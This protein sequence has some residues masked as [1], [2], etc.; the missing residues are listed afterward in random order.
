MPRS[1]L[2]DESVRIL[3][4]LADK[5][6]RDGEPDDFMGVLV[7][8]GITG[9]VA[10]LPRSV[11]ESETVFVKLLRQVSVAP[12]EEITPQQEETGT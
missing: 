8:F 11:A 6:E 10:I 2:R 3:R 1:S 4:A 12:Y 9:S 7:P 5:L